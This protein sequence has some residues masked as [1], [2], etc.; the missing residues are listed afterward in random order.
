MQLQVRPRQAK[1]IITTTIF[2]DRVAKSRNKSLLEVFTK[3]IM[4]Y[5]ELL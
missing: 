3:Y 2:L 5:L 1:L 4:L